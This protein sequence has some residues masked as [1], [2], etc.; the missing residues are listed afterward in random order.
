MEKRY[1]KTQENP[2]R[3]LSTGGISSPYQDS[4]IIAEPFKQAINRPKSSM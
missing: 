2:G 3:S 4:K 1:K